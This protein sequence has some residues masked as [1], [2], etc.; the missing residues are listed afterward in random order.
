MAENPEAPP[1]RVVLAYLVGGL[2]AIVGF[3]YVIPRVIT[4]FG[5]AVGLA[6]GTAAIAVPWWALALVSLGVGGTGITLVVKLLVMASK[7]ASEQPY[8]WTVPILGISGGLILDVAKEYALDNSILK[9]VPSA[10]IAFL[11]VV[12]GACYKRGGFA[13][14]F[15]AIIL[16]L[17]PPIAVLASNLDPAGRASLADVFRSVP[18]AVWIRIA[19]FL[20]VG[21]G[22]VVLHYLTFRKASK[23][24]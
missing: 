19:A 22:V 8:E 21:V 3:V 12:A 2:G 13:W 15:V 14:R 17:A 23:R 5:A 24:S 16:I 11:V 7:E 10:V 1:T 20:L 9:F 18:L 6:V 4:A